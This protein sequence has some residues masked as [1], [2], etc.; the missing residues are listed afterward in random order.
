MVLVSGFTTSTPFST[1]DPS[2][3]GNEGDTWSLSVAPAL[4]AAGYP[5]FTA[6]EGPS[7]DGNAPGNAPSP[8]VG[9]GQQ[10]PPPD[11]TVNTGGDVDQNGQRLGQFLAFL[12]QD[13]GVTD[14]QLV[15]HSDGGIWSR[16]AITQSAN[17]PGV[18]ITSLTTLGTPH[19]GSFVADLA[20]GVG[21]L[22]CPAGGNGILKYLCEGVQEI[23]SII[24]SVLGPTALNELT[25]SFTSTWNTKQSI[26][27]C[28]VTTVAGTYVQVPYVGFLLPQYYDPSDTVVGQSSALATPSTLIDFAPVVPPNIPNLIDGGTF[29]VVHSPS[30][31]FIT[32]DNL[33]NTPSVTAVV[34]NAVAA[35]G[36]TATPCSAGPAAGT[37]PVAAGGPAP[38]VADLRLDPLM[39]TGPRR[40]DRLP[41]TAKGDIVAGN[42][43]VRVTCGSQVFLDASSPG[44]GKAVLAPVPAVPAQ[45]VG[46]GRPR[47]RAAPRPPPPGAP[48]RR[49]R[50]GRPRRRRPRGAQGRDPGEH[51]RGL[52]DA[53]PRPGRTRHVAARRQRDQGPRAVDH[54]PNGAAGDGGRGARALMRGSALER[55]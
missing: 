11:V 55:E 42:R 6:P 19:E 16:S 23:E 13:Y 31:S 32:P 47:G 53:A 36:G 43:G 7:S 34:Q 39:V 12:N 44:L 38:Q 41:P 9:P 25:S 4:K 21:G 40:P 46:L 49:P 26:G 54:A 17:Y 33:L 18:T 20:L 5:V 1:P 29:P 22:D 3:A 35:G 37:P 15:G 52:P 45:P 51:R 8:C 28:P 48:A 24:S 27:G 10:A 50:Q 2:C 30:L 14:V